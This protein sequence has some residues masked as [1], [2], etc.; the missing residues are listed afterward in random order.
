M[1]KARV[2]VPKSVKKGEVFEVKSLVSHKMETGLRKNKKTGKKIPRDIINKFSVT[3]GGKEVFGADWHPAVSANPYTSFF[4]KASK[5]GPMVLKWTDD[6][7]K[8]TEKTVKIKVS[9]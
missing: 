6:A 8:V 9:G 4:V 7:G 2:K 3:Y 1:A 5:S